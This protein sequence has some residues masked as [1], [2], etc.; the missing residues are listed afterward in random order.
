MEDSNKATNQ[1]TH[2]N[3][4]K[5]SKKANPTIS[6]VQTSER[7]APPEKTSSL[8]D[9]VVSSA[10]PESEACVTEQNAESAFQQSKDEQDQ[11]GDPNTKYGAVTLLSLLPEISQ[12]RN[13]D[14]DEESA[15]LKQKHRLMFV[16]LNFPNGLINEQ[17]GKSKHHT[18]GRVQQYTRVLQQL[19]ISKDYNDCKAT[20][21]EDDAK[22]LWTASTKYCLG[23]ECDATGTK[24]I[25]L[26]RK[27]KD[28]TL[29]RVVSNEEI[30]DYIRDA[31]LSVDHAK[32]R[33]TYNAIK[34]RRIFTISKKDVDS[35]IRTC[36]HCC[37][38]H[39]I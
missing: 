14:L 11:N 32:D 19:S 27:N 18:A 9:A 24:S 29:L 34:A 6:V 20:L 35:F 12:L 36:P 10:N 30:F 33:T 16:E 22:V 28:G 2:F 17:D 7:K 37:N 26:L 31:H 3:K 39:D 25:S 8:Q 13:E 15:E 23:E 5:S 1:P 4:T 38:E 21:S